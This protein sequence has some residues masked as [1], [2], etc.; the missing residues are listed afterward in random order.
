MPTVERS[1]QP[2]PPSTPRRSESVCA[3]PSPIVAHDGRAPSQE[4]EE[5]RELRREDFALRR[6]NEILG[7]A[8][9]FLAKKLDEVRTR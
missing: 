9:V 6:A 4:R 2:Q 7:F 8:S 1:A 3:M 5:I